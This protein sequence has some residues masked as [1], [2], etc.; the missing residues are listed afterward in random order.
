MLSQHS[1]GHSS[2]PGKLLLW[3][4]LD[5]GTQNRSDRSCNWN[6]LD[7]F[8]LQE[9]FLLDSNDL[10]MLDIVTALGSSWILTKLIKVL[11]YG[12]F[13]C[14]KANLFRYLGI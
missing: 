7:P 14:I 3:E 6:P 1:K 13:I 2:F 4:R 9:K 11:Y 5:P 8:L 12:K 10:A